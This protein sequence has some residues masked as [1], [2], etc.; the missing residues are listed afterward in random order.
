MSMIWLIAVGRFKL[1]GMQ[2]DW[3]YSGV[4]YT[5]CTIMWNFEAS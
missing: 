2:R 5:K 4:V 1:P 3:V